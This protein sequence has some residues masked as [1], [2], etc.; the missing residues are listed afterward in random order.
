MKFPPSHK[1]CSLALG[2]LVR[3]EEIPVLFSYK[4]GTMEETERNKTTARHACRKF[5]VFVK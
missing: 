2:Y 1:L 5:W 4:E 3:G